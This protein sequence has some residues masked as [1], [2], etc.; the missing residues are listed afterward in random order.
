[1]KSAPKASIL[2]PTR[3][4]PGY[5]DVTLRT[6]APQA[7]RQ[8]AEVLV[9]SD[10]PDEESR[11]VAEHHG[12]RMLELPSPSGLNAVRNEGVKAASGEL[13][14]FVDDD[15]IAPPGWLEIYLRAAHATPDQDVFGGPIRAQLEGGG[16]RACG[17]EKPPITTLDLGGEDRDVELVWGANMA[18]RRHA[19]KWLGGF[20]ETIV[21]TGDEEDWLRRYV[22]EGN[23]VRYLADAGIVHR[24]SASDARLT[25]L[26]RTAYGRGKAARRYDERK[27]MA[28]SIG[29][30]LL[31][32]VG[33]A[34][35][36]FR[37]R[38]A[39]GIVC[40]VHTAGRLHQALG[41]RLR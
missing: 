34:W 13:L 25:N 18:I 19:F 11:E 37:R 26:A 38:C 21:G 36:A 16:P 5:L 32:L 7:E 28:P 2:I 22:S 17:R 20:D 39:L 15:V 9:I 40:A 27:Q 1:V 24:R 33:C 30:E 35:H 10:G 31:T 23:R 29:G 8:G 4:R 12:A 14:V 6:I 3:S 41:D